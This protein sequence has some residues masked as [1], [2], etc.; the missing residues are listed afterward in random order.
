[1]LLI[2][3]ILQPPPKNRFQA[4][5]VSNG[6]AAK[7]GIGKLPPIYPHV[8]MAVTASI[9]PPTHLDVLTMELVFN[10][11]GVELCHIPLGYAC[12]QAHMNTAAAFT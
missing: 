7:L 12:T 2:P 8:K 3:A 10:K 6:M 11:G 1:M 5:S 4:R 9:A